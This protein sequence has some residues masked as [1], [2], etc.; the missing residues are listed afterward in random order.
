MKKWL[1]GI[2]GVLG[3]GFILIYVILHIA[4]SGTAKAF[5]EVSIPI[6]AVSVP[7]LN[8]TQGQV[9]PETL[10]GQVT[11]VSFFASWCGP[12]HLNHKLLLTLSQNNSLRIVGINLRDN[13]HEA[14]MWL[15][16]NGNPFKLVGSDPQGHMAGAWGVRGIPQIFVVD[17]KGTIRFRH[18]GVLTMDRID[19]VLLPLIQKLEAE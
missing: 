13:T 8:G 17:K 5:E 10:T 12:C 9:G 7:L 4:T 1:L 19:Q 6:P 11:L 2:A 3:G 18:T 16:E 14:E 15:I